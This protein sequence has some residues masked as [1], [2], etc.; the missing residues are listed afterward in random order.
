MVIFGLILAVKSVDFIVLSVL[1][2]TFRI[3]P[4]QKAQQK[5]FPQFKH[6]VVARGS[7]IDS[8]IRYTIPELQEC[9]LS[10]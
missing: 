9:L 2:C 5:S 4:S 10:R 1:L 8:L 6:A 3:D 7:E